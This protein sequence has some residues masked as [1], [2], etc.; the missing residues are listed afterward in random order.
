MSPCSYSV[1]APVSK[2]ETSAF[3]LKGAGRAAPFGRLLLTV[4]LSF[5]GIVRFYLDLMC[6]FVSYRIVCHVSL[7]PYQNCP[8]STHHI[9]F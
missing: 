4:G 2:S 1:G 6:G 7:L 3:I 9:F 5:S 8:A